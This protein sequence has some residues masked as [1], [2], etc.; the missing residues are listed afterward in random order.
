MTEKHKPSGVLN[1]LEEKMRTPDDRFLRL[2]ENRDKALVFF[3]GE[4]YY[5]FVY[6]DGTQYRKWYAGCD[7]QLIKRVAMNVIHC[8]I[9]KEKLEI[10]GA[11][12]FEQGK[13]FFK[14]V[15]NLDNDYG[16]HDWLFQI[17]RS[18]DRGDTDTV[19]RIDAEHELSDKEKEKLMSMKLLDLEELY[20]SLDGNS[21]KKQRQPDEPTKDEEAEEADDDTLID[22][23]ELNELISML[24]TFPDFETVGRKLVKEFGVKKVKE[25]RKSQLKK[26]LKY[27]D[28]LTAAEHPESDDDSPF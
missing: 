11:K 25:L 28:K 26:A 10:L 12:V 3:A 2:E 17:V 27:V 5:R 16:L 24:K 23:E 13:R 20:D 15:R 4:V 18:G 22:K 8:N 6:W 14:T 1:D 9:E 21:G 7:K 19:Y